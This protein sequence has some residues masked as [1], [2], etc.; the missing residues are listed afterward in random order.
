MPVVCPKI[1]KNESKKYSK[2]Y[3]SYVVTVNSNYIIKSFKALSSFVDPSFPDGFIICK[4]IV[5]ILFRKFIK[6]DF[7]S[8]FHFVNFSAKMCLH[9]TTCD[10]YNS[11]LYKICTTLQ[12]VHETK[13]RFTN[14]FVRYLWEFGGNCS[15]K[16]NELIQFFQA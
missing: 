7:I 16:I 15:F 5:K 13:E 1:S 10:L 11:C 6:N 8:S 4:D 9:K 14:S 12:L 3:F 2:K